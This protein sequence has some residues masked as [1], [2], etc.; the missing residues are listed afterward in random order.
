MTSRL[1]SRQLSGR[2]PTLLM[3][4]NKCVV[5][6]LLEGNLVDGWLKKKSTSCDILSVGPLLAEMI[7]LPF[8]GLSFLWI[9]GKR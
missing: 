3:I 7:G 5:C 1:T 9:L 2:V 4:C 6:P 8:T